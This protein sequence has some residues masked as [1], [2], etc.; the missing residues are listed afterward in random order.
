M[1]SSSRCRLVVFAIGPLVFNGLV[2]ATQAADLGSPS[3]HSGWRSPRPA[4]Y[5]SA[6]SWTGLYAGLQAGYG[7]GNTETKAVWGQIAGPAEQFEYDPRGTVGGLH[8]G[9]NAEVGRLVLGM[10][11]DLEASGIEG[12]GFGNF[13]AIHNSSVDWLGSMRGRLGFIAGSTL[14]YATG[15][16]AIAGVSLEQQGAS[17]LS[18][19]STNSETRTG[20]TV[21]AGV[22]HAFAPKLTVRLEYRYV[23][24]GAIVYANP[25]LGMRETS[26]LSAHTMRAGLSF[27]F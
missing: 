4:G 13:S 23:D 27:R 12:S 19:F 6:P 17:A 14:L 25:T 5:H 21:G 8:I 1:R 2:V 10:E 11:A 22:E 20:W 15:G 18:A 3:H 24:L 26:E 7:W 16:L 9:Y